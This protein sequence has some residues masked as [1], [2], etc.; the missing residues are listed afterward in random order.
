VLPGAL[1]RSGPLW[2]LTTWIGSVKQGGDNRKRASSHVHPDDSSAPVCHRADQPKAADALGASVRAARN[3][4]LQADS[5]G[6]GGAAWIIWCLDLLAGWTAWAMLRSLTCR[7][8]SGR[9]GSQPGDEF[10][11]LGVWG[12]KR[13][14]SSDSP[15]SHFSLSIKSAVFPKSPKHP[16]RTIPKPSPDP[17]EPSPSTTPTR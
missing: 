12:S 5:G 2:T 8:T 17:P 10:D 1:S 15:L 13:F 3:G 16:L 4:I 11:W 7:A 6:D 9:A 14:D